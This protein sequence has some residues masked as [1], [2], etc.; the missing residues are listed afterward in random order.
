MR[1]P[2]AASRHGGKYGLRAWRDQ[3]VSPRPDIWRSP[4]EI[5]TARGRDLE[6]VLDEIA[7]AKKMAEDRGLT[8]GE[9]KTP[10][11]QNPAAMGASE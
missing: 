3:F 9:V 6:E 4:Q 2:R 11:K 1:I 7:E 10:L 5:V 8:L